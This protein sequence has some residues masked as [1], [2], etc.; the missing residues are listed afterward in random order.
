MKGRRHRRKRCQNGGRERVSGREAPPAKK[1]E[2]GTFSAVVVVRG[3]RDIKTQNAQKLK[4]CS[5]LIHFLKFGCYV[6]AVARLLYM[7][8][9]C[10]YEDTSLRTYISVFLIDMV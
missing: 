1:V 10:I 4:K 2:E 6:V 8:V 7:C 5:A 3:K 9:F